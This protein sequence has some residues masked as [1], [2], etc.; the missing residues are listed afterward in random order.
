MGTLESSDDP[1]EMQCNA[2]F[3]QGL[4]GLLRFKQPSR[5][6]IYHHFETYTCDCDPLKYT[7]AYTIM[8]LVKS[9]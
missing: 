4:H 2:A 3:H 6:E 1:D 8:T 5:T 7:M 9:A